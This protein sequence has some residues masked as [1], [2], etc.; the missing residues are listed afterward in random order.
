MLTA[1]GVWYGYELALARGRYFGLDTTVIDWKHYVQVIHLPSV[2]RQGL[3]VESGQRVPQGFP[4]VP[5]RDAGDATS[6]D[7]DEDRVAGIGGR[8]RIPARRRERARQR[9]LAQPGKVLD[10]QVAAGQQAGQRLADLHVLADDKA[11]HLA[12]DG[13]QFRIHGL[14]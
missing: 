11:A 5:E 7:V 3:G 1:L 14:L 8:T 10:Q 12:R 13:V 2:V 6:F 4:S 9:G